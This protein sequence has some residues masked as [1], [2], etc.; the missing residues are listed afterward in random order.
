M[1]WYTS[2]TS[3]WEGKGWRGGRGRVGN[4]VIFINHI[5]LLNVTDFKMVYC[6]GYGNGCLSITHT[7]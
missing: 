6:L 7:T 1:S 4:K 3:P 5:Q 2:H